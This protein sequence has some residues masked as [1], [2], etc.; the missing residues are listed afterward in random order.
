MGLKQIYL[1]V[2][3]KDGGFVHEISFDGYWMDNAENRKML[4]KKKRLD[5]ASLQHPVGRDT[6][7]TFLL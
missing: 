2:S 5:G 4:R 6:N 3:P 1:V 7:E